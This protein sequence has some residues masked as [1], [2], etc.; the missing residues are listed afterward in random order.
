LFTITILFGASLTSEE[1]FLVSDLA[2]PHKI[3]L[4]NK[5]ESFSNQQIRGY[6]AKIFQ[7]AAVNPVLERKPE[8][9]RK[10]WR[11]NILLNQSLVDA[12]LSPRRTTEKI[13]IGV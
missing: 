8:W 12:V 7:D 2:S 3:G 11:S 6:L 9:V 4:S 10:D 13:T 1:F 5:S